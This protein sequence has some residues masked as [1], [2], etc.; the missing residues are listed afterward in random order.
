MSIVEDINLEKYALGLNPK[1][2]YPSGSVFSMRIDT[3]TKCMILRYEKSKLATDVRITPVWTPSL[4]DPEWRATSI[5]ITQAGET[6]THQ[7]WEASIPLLTAPQLF[8]R[9]KFTLP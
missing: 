1:Q 8:M 3:T 4:T 2:S 9:L 5:E 7:I 6:E